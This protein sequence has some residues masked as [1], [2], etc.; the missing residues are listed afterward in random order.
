MFLTPSWHDLVIYHILPV[1]SLRFVLSA[2]GNRAS[3][4]AKDQHDS[5]SL[6][7]KPGSLWQAQSRGNYSPTPSSSPKATPDSS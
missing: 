1:A 6:L 2:N 7:H 4:E 5:N 3:D